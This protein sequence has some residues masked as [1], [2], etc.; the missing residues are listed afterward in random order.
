MALTPAR[1]PILKRAKALPGFLK[2]N[3]LAKHPLLGPDGEPNPNRDI[4]GS[5][6]T[7]GGVALM[8]ECLGRWLS[9]TDR[10]GDLENVDIIRKAHAK[11]RQ[12]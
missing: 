12:Q 11:M 6:L 7:A 3:G 2:P 8:E 4:S 1:V 5:D 10:G 9:Y